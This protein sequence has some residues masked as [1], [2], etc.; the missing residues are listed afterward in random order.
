M[1]ST[2]FPSAFEYQIPYKNNELSLSSHN[3]E[4]LRRNG[5]RQQKGNSR[6]Q[7]CAYQSTIVVNVYFSKNAIEERA[8]LR[9]R[10][11]SKGK[12]RSQ[13]DYADN[14]AFSKGI[15][16]TSNIDDL[17]AERQDWNDDVI[18]PTW[19]EEV[20]N[21]KTGN[22][23]FL[24]VEYDCRMPR[25]RTLP[26]QSSVVVESCF[27]GLTNKGRLIFFGVATGKSD[28]AKDDGR[29]DFAAHVFGTITPTPNYGPLTLPPAVSLFMSGVGFCYRDPTTGQ[30]M[31]EYAPHGQH[32]KKVMPF[33]FYLNDTN[34]SSI[35]D[36]VRFHVD[37]SI[38][39]LERDHGTNYKSLVLGVLSKVSDLVL[40]KHLTKEI[41]S[42]LM[43]DNLYHLLFVSHLL[44][45]A[46]I[47]F[48]ED[49]PTQETQNTRKLVL[50]EICVIA[51]KVAQ[52]FILE[53]E[54]EANH[55]LNAIMNKDARV[56]NELMD[57]DADKMFSS[58]MELKQVLKRKFWIE[59]IIET[60]LG[61]ARAHFKQFLADRF[62]GQNLG[63]TCPPNSSYDLG[64]RLHVPGGY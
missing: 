8:E 21:V 63:R 55:Y 29:E 17:L 16:N 42:E 20:F 23:L 44:R 18:A 27:N 7:P 39:K 25:V 28:A 26:S 34:L 12:R 24:W 58:S 14:L 1:D 13:R 11:V 38:S 35:E 49:I 5:I 36:R 54:T 37:D 52:T 33:P 47:W 48:A 2:G 6:G 57:T 22:L 43:I 50:I 4:T 40:E 46:E 56:D 59:S 30:L 31:P 41:R 62:M 9:R 32:P 53:Y 3:G 45:R 51:H 10:L 15:T 60:Y 19:D 61:A 64:I